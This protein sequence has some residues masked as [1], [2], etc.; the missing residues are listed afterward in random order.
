MTGFLE[1]GFL[2]YVVILVDGVFSCDYKS[3]LAPFSFDFFSI[4]FSTFLS[5]LIPFDFFC[6]F[7][8]VLGG[9]MTSIS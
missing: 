5:F 9:V 3:K 8:G 4:F 1:I 7:T 6:F 2:S